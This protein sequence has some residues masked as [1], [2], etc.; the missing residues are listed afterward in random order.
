MPTEDKVVIIFKHS[1]GT[2]DSWPTT[3]PSGW[4]FMSGAARRAWAV[5][6]LARWNSTYTYQY[7]ERNAR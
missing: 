7:I 4:E 2:L 1:N 5:R 6:R 3:R